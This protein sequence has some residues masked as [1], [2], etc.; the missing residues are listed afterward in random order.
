MAHKLE[1]VQALS[2]F[3]KSEERLNTIINHDR[4]FILIY[5]NSNPKTYE[6]NLKQYNLHLFK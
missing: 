5:C 3:R 2:K 6:F 4:N 1:L